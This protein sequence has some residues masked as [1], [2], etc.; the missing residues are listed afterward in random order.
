VVRGIRE[1]CD[2]ISK[3]T[4]G[5]Y[6]WCESLADLREQEMK[7]A[8]IEL[9]GRCPPEG[10]ILGVEAGRLPFM[11]KDIRDIMA[12]CES[13]EN[14]HCLD[15]ISQVEKRWE[16]GIKPAKLK[17]GAMVSGGRPAD[18]TPKVHAAWPESEAK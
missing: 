18:W 11:K 13:A 1:S 10:I 16:A 4:D 7:E 6:A 8:A 2:R 5:A 14:Q 9:V 3:E 17:L 15:I 12:V